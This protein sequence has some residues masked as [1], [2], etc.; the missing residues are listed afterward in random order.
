MVLCYSCDDN[1]PLALTERFIVR[2]RIVYRGRDETI[3]AR[4]F[5]VNVCIGCVRRRQRWREAAM[6]GA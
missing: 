2:D 4:I 5:V 6:G 3:E 1:V